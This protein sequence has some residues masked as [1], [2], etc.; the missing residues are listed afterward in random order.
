MT[1][2]PELLAQISFISSMFGLPTWK[3]VQLLLI[4]AILCPGSRTVCNVLRTLGLDQV[5][6][7]HKYHRVLSKDKWKSYTFCG[8]LLKALVDA[9]VDEGKPLN[10]VIDG[11]IERRWGAKISKRGIYRDAVRSSKTH[12]VKTSGVRWMVLALVVKLPWLE[13]DKVWALPIMSVICPSER[14]HE[15]K[16][17]I[18]MTATDRARQMMTWL[19]KQKDT[20]NRDMY[21]LGDMEFTTYELYAKAIE[22]GITLI[23]RGRID[24]KLFDLPTVKDPSQPGPQAKIGERQVS[25]QERIEATETAWTE[26][27]FSHWYNETNKELKFTSGVSVWY[28]GGHTPCVIK[29]VLILDPTGKSDPY[30][31]FSTNTTLE[32][33]E[34]VKKYVERW[35][36]EVSFAEVRR[37]LGVETQRQWS[38]KAIDRTTPSLMALMSLICLMAKPIFDKQKLV[39]NSTAWYQKKKVTFSDVIGAVKMEIWEH[40]IFLGQPNQGDVKSYKD[41]IRQLWRTISFSAA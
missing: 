26:V 11:T 19:K 40:N 27:T 10:F 39:P 23:S 20:L 30:L 15:S 3:K 2:P 5:K 31:I 38:D 34:I 41:V 14:Y 7:F 12:F 24:A 33:V 8:K 29:W 36:I 32:A 21:L 16:K 9:F 1:F 18:H 13:D 4:G 35:R 6:A 22:T 17:R 37:H 25:M 28:S